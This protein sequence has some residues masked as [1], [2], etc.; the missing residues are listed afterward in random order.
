MGHERRKGRKAGTN[1]AG[2]SHAWLSSDGESV[3]EKPLKDS[4]QARDRAA[5]FGDDPCDGSERS[6][7]QAVWTLGSP[8]ETSNSSS[9]ERRQR[10]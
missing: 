2:R 4:E 10:A 8:L 9:R 1:P 5:A 3:S 6:W 7:V